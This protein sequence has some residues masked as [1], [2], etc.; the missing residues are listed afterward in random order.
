VGSSGSKELT[1]RDLG[2]I[3][4]RRRWII[5]GA[6]F[7]FAVGGGVYCAT[8][9][10]RYEAT[11]TIQVQ[12]K[13]LDR[14]GLE[15]L[16]GAAAESDGDSVT[17]N[18][19]IQTQ[20]AI[21]Q[22]DTL[23]LKTIEGLHLEKTAEFQPHWSAAGW[24]LSQVLPKQNA[25]QSRESPDATLEDSPER[26]RQALAVFSGNLKV[27]PLPGTRLI[28]VTYRSRDRKIAA[29]VV[30]KLTQA[31][32]GY[33]FQTRFEATNQAAD[34]LSGQLG[35]LRQQSE[36]LQRQ[37]AELQSKS[38]VYTL[39]TVDPSGRDQ[40]YS[41][42]LDQLQQ[43]T[44]ALS[45]AEQNRILRGA[46][47]HAAESGDAE[48]LSGLAGNTMNGATVNNNL[49]LIQNLRGQEASEEAALQQAEAKY[50]AAYPKL[51]ELRSNLT[52]LHASIKQEVDRLKARAK[53]DYDDAV[54]DED[55]TRDR[56]NKVKAEA[57]SLNNK[58]VDFAILRQEADES[59]KLYQELLERFKEAGVLES[60]KGSMITVVDPGRI[61]GDAKDPNVR[62][63]MAGA[64]AGG[65]L[66]GFGL[67][68]VAEAT[69]N[70]LYTLS[71][72]EEVS[73]KSLLGA[74][75]LLVVK[76]RSSL[77]RSGM[78]LVSLRE[79]HSQF[80]EAARSI[81]TELLLTSSRL[82]SRVVL[83]TSSV[84]GEGKTTV[85]AN[86]AV[87]L[88]Q[89][90]QR[91]LA[92]DTDLRRGTLKTALD[93]KAAPGLSELLQG[94][95]EAPDLQSVIQPVKGVPSLNAISAGDAPEYPS[96]LLG[97]S[98]LSRWLEAWRKEYDFVVMDSAPILSVTDPLILASLSDIALLIVRPG[99][100]ER[101]QLLRGHQLLS[102]SRQ[103]PVA[104]V[105]NGLPPEAEG[106]S[107]YFGA[108]LSARDEVEAL[109]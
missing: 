93:L 29:D 39:G 18:M 57:D 95:S 77:D 26:R 43:A 78:G 15:S 32:V 49:G 68:F 72:I 94:R 104:T 63:V 107:S 5:F 92:V 106:Y 36:Q 61:P 41:G 83:V 35:D 14:L 51:E 28:Q 27:K 82:K 65:L 91:V 17:A 16:N 20:A 59:R 81:R 85:A 30:N 10:R 56:Y 69:D 2:V 88:A 66:L 86:L 12:S 103:R 84:A 74:T 31:L 40:A 21:L 73:G 79:P 70:R 102:R 6:V 33:S 58:S 96:E 1:I 64:V 87:L 3:V 62:L 60:L 42:V 24:L 54:R 19:E 25:G 75:P 23:A 53:S 97:S 50:G 38:G 46:I 99:L 7:L 55:E 71:E 76:S 67:A 9:T 44:T 8:A 108:P 101:P 37:V 89:S 80:I 47:L 90:G 100:T 109:R 45:Q 98:E 22:S 11:S 48:M 52:G 105:V 4:R 34:W 13:N